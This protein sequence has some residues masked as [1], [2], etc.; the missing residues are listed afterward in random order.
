[1]NE[2]MNEWMKNFNRRSSH[3]HHGLKG[4]EP[5]QHAHWRDKGIAWRP[6]ASESGRHSPTTFYHFWDISTLRLYTQNAVN[7]YP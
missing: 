6:G 3:G 2:W 4:R 5:A 1:M 7:L